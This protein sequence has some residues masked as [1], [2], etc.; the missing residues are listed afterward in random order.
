M[1]VNENKGKRKSAR[2]SKLKSLVR[3]SFDFI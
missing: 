1:K 3:H 2:T